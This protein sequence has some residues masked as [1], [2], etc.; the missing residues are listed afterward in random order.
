MWEE[1]GGWS[2]CMWR[3]TNSDHSLAWLCFLIECEI[4]E[5]RALEINQL[6]DQSEATKPFACS[7]A[8]TNGTSKG[9]V[10][11]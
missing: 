1:V 2:I 3:A 6:A 10:D 11:R 5:I 7:Q 8:R 9:N 4:R